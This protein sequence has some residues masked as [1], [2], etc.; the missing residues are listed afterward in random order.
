[1]LKKAFKLK[2]SITIEKL[3]KNGHRSKDDHFFYNYK[4]N[5]SAHPKFAVS[6]IKKFKLNAPQ[7]N[8]FKRQ[9]FN[10]IEQILKNNPNLAKLNFNI[11]IILHTIP[12][13]KKNFSTFKDRIEK[14]LIKLS[15]E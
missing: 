10:S 13:D 8:R 9:I 6:V 15:N 11:F 14:Q 4:K 5:N 3:F 12:T 7:R 1:M 2:S